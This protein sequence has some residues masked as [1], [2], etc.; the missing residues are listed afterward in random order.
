MEL[1]WREKTYEFK[2]RV[3]E[4]KKD[5]ER[6]NNVY[7]NIYGFDTESV[8]L[9]DRY[10][11]QCFQI[12]NDVSGECIKYIPPY[13]RGL[14]HFIDYFVTQFS[15]IEFLNRYCFMYAHNLM[16]DWLQ[17]IKYYPDLISI[18]KTGIG[19]DHDL[20]IFRRKD[21]YCVLKKGGLFTGTAPHFTLKVGISK[22]E[23]VNI[24]FR[25]TFSFF[26]S[27]LD[28]IAKQLKLD[29]S[30]LKRQEN[31]G[32]IDFREIKE[33]EDKKYFEE[34]AK[35]DAKITR[36]VGEEIR[37]LHVN[38]SMQRMRVSAPGFAINYLLHTIPEGTKIING[39]K[40]IDTMQLILETYA[41]GRTGGIYHGVINNV[42]VIDIH[43]SY[44]ASMTTL[45]SFSETMQYI[46]YLN[47]EELTQ[48]ELLDIINENHCF[49]RISGEELNSRYPSLVRESSGKLTPIYGLFENVS[50]TGVECCV[51][52]KSGDLKISKVHDLVILVEMEEP[53]ILPFKKFAESAYSRKANSEK[54]SSEYISAKLV[55]N[56][57]YGKL[58]ESR[59][60]TFVADE[61]KNI[62]L[63]YTKAVKEQFSKMYY[64]EYI[65]S[66]GENS[67]K[68]FE[69]I[70]PD[71]VE[72]ILSNFEENEIEYASFGKLSLTKLEYGRYAIPAG[73]SLITATS[74]ARLLAV[75]KSTQSIY[76]DTDSA[77]I[78]DFDNIK[79]IEQLKEA[80]SWLP[81]F[82]Q[83]VKMGDEL[84]DLDCEIKN[85]SGYLAGV[86]RYYLDNEI[87]RNCKTKDNKDVC[88]N[89]ELEKKCKVKKAVHGIPTAPFQ[90]AEE[91]I[92]KLAMG[93]NN[94]YEGRE[95]P[96]GVKESKSILEIGRFESKKYESQ[97]KLDD[98]L[99]WIKTENGW[100]GEVKKLI[101]IS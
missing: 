93:E 91:M 39:D 29:T 72:Q 97:F 9:S 36:L 28:K 84:G 47:P 24:L 86:K 95:R 13:G 71:L 56:S 54:D 99:N 58:I 87:H 19:V 63:P 64:E 101:D 90:Q 76:W 49:M 8:N 78:K 55:L 65:K 82:I 10:E 32:K 38:A 45:P 88:N 62:I 14:E 17:L 60:E 35:I 73:A 53:S 74:R 57:S 98:R 40:D 22:R 50:T 66:L 18:A 94:I 33:S 31:L 42:S 5:K 6:Q 61:V 46:K 11:P 59:T 89:C 85:A 43:S 30:K 15:H 83:D 25:D 7:C 12:S 77:F 4:A 37:K 44:P 26:P 96:K 81:D 68:D 41:G 100:I 16:Y 2:N 79:V 1:K 69:E 21:Y 23:F 3:L 67:E 80:S 52:I 20:E 75:I 51:G 70:Y 34:Y 27:S 48:E 92:Q